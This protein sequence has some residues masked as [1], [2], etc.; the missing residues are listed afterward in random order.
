MTCTSRSSSINH[1]FLFEYERMAEEYN[2]QTIAADDPVEVV[3][4]TL[5]KELGHN[6]VR[7]QIAY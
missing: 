6:F 7:P 2:F 4:K 1:R 5:R 3:Q